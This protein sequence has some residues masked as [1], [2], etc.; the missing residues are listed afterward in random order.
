MIWII[1]NTTLVVLSIGIYLVSAF[2]MA[3]K[4]PH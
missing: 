3:S 4:D 1:I 2:G